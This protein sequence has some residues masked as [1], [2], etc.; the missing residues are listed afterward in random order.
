MQY[1]N[2]STTIAKLPTVYISGD[3]SDT[4]YIGTDKWKHSINFT[5]W[6]SVRFYLF[7][8]FIYIWFNNTLQ[9][10]NVMEIISYLNVHVVMY[11]ETFRTVAHIWEDM[12]QRLSVLL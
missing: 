5:V 6:M 7:P 3:D 2:I 1:I 4:S 8:L 11:C 9:L 10:Y 12:V